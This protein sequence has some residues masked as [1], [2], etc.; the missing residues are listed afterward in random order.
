[1][2]VDTVGDNLALVAVQVLAGES[3]VDGLHLGD[4]ETEIPVEVALLDEVGVDAGLQTRIPDTGIGIH[5]HGPVTGGHRNLDI[6]QQVVGNALVVF[7]GHVET[8]PEERGVQT[9]VEDAVALPGQFGTVTVI[10]DD[11]QLIVVADGGIAV[12]PVIVLGGQRTVHAVAGLEFQLADLP[13]VR[14]HEV[15]LG[16]IVTAGDGPEVAGAVFR[17]EER[18]VVTAVRSAQQYLGTVSVVRTGDQREDAVGISVTR[19]PGRVGTVGQVRRLVGT[20][21]LGR[22]GLVAILQVLHFHTGGSAQVVALLAPL[23]VEV[24]HRGVGELGTLHVTVGQL[25][26]GR[27]TGAETA[28]Q[29]GHSPEAVEVDG[30][31]GGKFQVFREVEG[32]VAHHVH[33]QGRTVVLVLVSARNRVVIGVQQVV[34]EEEVVGT[35]FQERG[36]DRRDHVGGILRGTVETTARQRAALHRVGHIVVD[37]PGHELLSGRV[38]AHTQGV[39]LQLGVDDG[40]LLVE[41]LERGVIVD[42]V[43]AA[44]EGETGLGEGRH[45]GNHLEPVGGRQFVGIFTE[46]VVIPVTAVCRRN[47]IFDIELVAGHLLPLVEVLALVGVVGLVGIELLQ[48]ADQA[49]ADGQ[50]GGLRFGD[51]LLQ[52]IVHLAFHPEFGILPAVDQVRLAGH[53]GETVDRGQ[54][55]LDLLGL[56]TFLGGDDHHAIR[57]AG[58]VERCGSRILEDRQRSDVGGVQGIERVGCRVV[59]TGDVGLVP[60][61]AVHHEQRL[62]GCI[63]RT[64][65]AEDDGTALTGLAGGGRKGTGHVASEG[66]FQGGNRAVFQ[67]FGGDGHG[68]TGVGLFGHTAI[69]CDH[70]LVQGYAFFLHRHIHHGTSLDRDRDRFHAQE[71]KVKRSGLG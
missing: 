24:E 55:D 17:R 29:V 2:N 14:P 28:V 65:T 66:F 38:Q 62:V 52:H 53:V 46:E 50:R 58:T 31:P 6:L 1:M 40:T 61:H 7:N 23:L 10:G 39:A 9:D 22:N 49:V 68:R 47:L 41:D 8:I 64:E 56:H 44:P 57:A 59:G 32:H 21:A 34:R 60:N 3:V 26:V 11:T 51:R 15:L 33:V 4:V 54:A 69:A 43:A 37:A 16:D 35:V 19:I 67:F 20:E 27:V 71:N 70:H 30:S 63:H 25:A 45:A 12:L 13:A 36:H 48:L 18:R 5:Q 42:G